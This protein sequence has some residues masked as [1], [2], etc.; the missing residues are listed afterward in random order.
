M[1]EKITALKCSKEISESWCKAY[2][3]SIR[4]G[5]KMS[6]FWKWSIWLGFIFKEK[7][8][9]KVHWYCETLSILYSC[10]IHIFKNVYITINCWPF[11]I[12]SHLLSTYCNMF[13]HCTIQGEILMYMWYVYFGLYCIFKVWCRLMWCIYLFRGWIIIALVSRIAGSQSEIILN[14]QSLQQLF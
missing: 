11:W 9:S 10:C 8:D 3:L 4:Y 6:T 2:G 7:E 5:F 13:K 1:G 12:L 14:L